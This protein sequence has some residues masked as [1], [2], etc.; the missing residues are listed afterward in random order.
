MR[1]FGFEPNVRMS[2]LQYS[3]IRRTFAVQKL[4]THGIHL[5]G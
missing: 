3:E 5:K 4:T 1:T 2:F